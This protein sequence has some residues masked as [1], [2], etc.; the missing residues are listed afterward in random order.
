LTEITGVHLFFR[1]T[2][3]GFSAQSLFFRA[4]LCLGYRQFFGAT[5]GRFI[6]K[7]SFCV[8]PPGCLF[9]SCFGFPLPFLSVSHRQHLS[10]APFVFAL[11]P[12]GLGPGVLFLGT[13]A[14]VLFGCV[15]Q[16]LAHL[17][18]A[19]G[20]MFAANCHCPMNDGGDTWRSLLASLVR[21]G[22]L[23]RAK[24]RRA[25]LSLLLSPP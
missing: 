13:A 15:P 4:L 14:F 19:D 17:N 5:L 16:G 1:L 12:S 9:F 21:P 2:L 24:A 11:P 22:A 8:L 10:S 3:L 6:L 7:T 23:W 20:T 18:G 25:L